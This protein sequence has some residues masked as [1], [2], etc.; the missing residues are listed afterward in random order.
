MG[1]FLTP[2]NKHRVQAP[3][4]FRSKNPGMLSHGYYLTKKENGNKVF[5]YFGKEVKKGE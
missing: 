1:T 3:Y 4:Y 5:Q 2:F